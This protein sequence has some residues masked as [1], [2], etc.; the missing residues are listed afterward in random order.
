MVGNAAVI[1]QRLEARGLGEGGGKRNVAN[2][3]QFR[4]GEKNHIR[5]IV[6]DGIDEASL[7]DDQ[8]FKAGLLG[9]DGASQAGGPG[10]DDHHVRKRLRAR[11]GLGAG[12]GFGSRFVGLGEPGRGKLDFG[13]SIGGQENRNLWRTKWKPVILTPRELPRFRGC[14]Q[15]CELFLDAHCDAIADGKNRGE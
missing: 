10:A 1:F 5:R 11:V 12:Q 2:L 7:I 3:Q 14:A 13:N 9:L 15:T 6:V 8:G 4:R